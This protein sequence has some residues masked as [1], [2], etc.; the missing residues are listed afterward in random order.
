M[1]KFVTPNLKTTILQIQKFELTPLP[2]TII[3]EECPF[4]RGETITIKGNRHITLKSSSSLPPLIKDEVSTFNLYRLIDLI[5]AKQA[6]Q[7][8][9]QP[10]QK[11]D[12]CKA[13][14]TIKYKEYQ[15]L[16]WEW[17]A[18]LTENQRLIDVK[19]LIMEITN[20]R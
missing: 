15:S 7:Q 19:M 2:L 4:W 5:I 17:T 6:W 11:V 8:I 12:Y 20:K 18:E 16:I 1:N 13:T 14:L 9:K 10:R 3:Y